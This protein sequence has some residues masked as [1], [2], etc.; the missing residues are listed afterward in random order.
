MKR[1]KRFFE[2][3]GDDYK[4]LILRCMEYQWDRWKTNSPEEPGID[5]PN[6]MEWEIKRAA[7]NWQSFI[8][9][10]FDKNLYVKPTS[11]VKPI[12]PYSKVRSRCYYN[13]LDYVLKHKEDHKDLK[14]CIGFIL[15]NAVFTDVN[16]WLDEGK[17][18]VG[19]EFIDRP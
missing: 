10:S 6:Y 2:D 17:Y 11:F 19:A 4:D 16:K 5:D 7:P 8:V 15:D 14:L 1:Y 18:G 9:K 3:V 13:A 12:N